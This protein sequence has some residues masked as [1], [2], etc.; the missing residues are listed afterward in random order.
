MGLGSENFGEAEKDPTGAI[1][2]RDKDIELR[3][4]GSVSR[5]ELA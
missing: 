4:H 2:F 1:V 3:V 5:Y